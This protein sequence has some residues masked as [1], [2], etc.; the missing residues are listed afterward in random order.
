MA[1]VNWLKIRKANADDVES[2]TKVSWLSFHQAFA[3]HPKNAPEDL[4]DY[5][6]KA[7]SNETIA[8]EVAEPHAIFLVAEK[9]NEIIGYAKLKSNS[10]ENGITANKPIEL[11][12]LYALQEYI[13]FGVGRALMH[14]SF[15]IARENKH[16]VMWLGVWEYNHR[17][18]KFYEK[19]GFK[20]VGEHIFQLGSD[21]QTDWLMQIS[22]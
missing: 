7:F 19:L 11:C 4:K 18:Q 9:D 3:D 14:E 13:G 21:P 6:D 10:I 17:A 22:L 16:D 1:E 20:R 8:A 15:K 2:L 12:R 5:M